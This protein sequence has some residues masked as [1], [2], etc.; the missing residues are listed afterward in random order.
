MLS[1]GTGQHPDREGGEHRLDLGR[2]LA[3]A[4]RRAV[5]GVTRVASLCEQVSGLGE[6]AMRPPKLR[7]CPPLSLLRSD[8]GGFSVNGHG[9]VL[10]T[11]ITASVWVCGNSSCLPAV[12][13]SG[14]TSLRSS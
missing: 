9:V 4:V 12:G 13:W 1:L 10:Q 2:D 11:S 8:G 6:Q 7:R 14:I 5:L 3:G